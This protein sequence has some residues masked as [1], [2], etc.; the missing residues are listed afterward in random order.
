M[1]LT[2]DEDKISVS[3]KNKEMFEKQ[4]WMMGEKDS[5]NNFMLNYEVDGESIKHLK[6]LQIPSDGEINNFLTG[7]LKNYSYG[8]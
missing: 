6:A 1:V 5:K 7:K 4:K 8:K 2:V 3:R